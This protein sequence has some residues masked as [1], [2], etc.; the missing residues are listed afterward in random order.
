VTG[1]AFHATCCLDRW[2]AARAGLRCRIWATISAKAATTIIPI[3]LTTGS[4][5]VRVGYVPN[6]N[7]PGGNV[8]GV[9]FLAAQ[10]VGIGITTGGPKRNDRISG[11]AHRTEVRGGQKRG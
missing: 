11:A 5:P 10:L 7:R 9:S 4:D 3:V 8:T 1:S 6:L 2:E